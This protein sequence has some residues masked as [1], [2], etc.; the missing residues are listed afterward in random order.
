MKC[1]LVL[2][3]LLLVVLGGCVP[4]EKE[5]KA[6]LADIGN[7]NDTINTA[8]LSLFLTLKDPKGPGVR[9]ELTNL[10]ILADKAWLP[11]T[12]APLKLDSEK[13]VASQVFL[14]G[15]AVPPGSYGR[16]RFTVTQSSYRL[17]SGEYQPASTGPDTLELEL[18]SPLFI[19]KDDSQCLFLTWDV[20]ES[21]ERYEKFRPVMTVAPPLRQLFVDLVYVTCPD[22]DTIFVIRSDKNWVT[23]S[24][25]VRGHP[26][27]IAMDPD[28]S[29]QHLYVLASRES[30]IK[31][32]ELNSQRV[33][34]SFSIPLIREASFMTIS[35]DGNWAYVLDKRDSY[36]SLL[37]LQ[38][39]TLVNRVRT[40]YEPQYET[41]LVDRNIL[42]VS[43]VISQT[44]SLRDPLNLNEVISIPVGYSPD[45]LLVSNNQLY[46]AERGANTVAIFDLETNQ[47]K[48]RLSVGFGPRRLLDNGNQ[49]YVSNYDDGSLSVI[50]PGQLDVGREIQGLGR[51]LEMVF[52]L[53][54]SSIYVGDERE[55]G[56]A[57]IDSNIN[58]LVGYIKLGARPL[59]LAIIQ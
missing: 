21:L 12:S 36:L 57:I 24:F 45:G 50:Y 25:G 53:N 54:Y 26:T 34:D 6:L 29:S 56:L 5:D 41:Y 17:G 1:R 44:V 33:V 48:S 49:I 55:A 7:E 10:E 59:G 13:I 3:V 58:Q 14:G 35:P 31:V 4:V 27:Y 16:L 19:D 32:V 52:D 11:V 37:D 42:A 51:P 9:L 8:R 43:S 2:A 15:R 46:I 22:I 30:R 20:L 23:D 47:I 40:G 39:G 28:P 18:A 38:S